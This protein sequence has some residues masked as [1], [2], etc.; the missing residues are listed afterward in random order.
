MNAEEYNNAAYCGAYVQ[1]YG[2]KGS[3]T[4]R[5]VDLCPECHS[6]ASR[7][8]PRGVCRDR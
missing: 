6:R 4:V 2:A 7:S 1:V 5:I 8:E 3:V